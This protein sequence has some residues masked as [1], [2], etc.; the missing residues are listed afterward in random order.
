MK[1]DWKK[2]AALVL[3][4]V[5][6]I[7]LLAGCAS[8]GVSPD[9]QQPSQPVT[10]T[11]A[12]PDSGSETPAVRPDCD[13]LTGGP[14]NPD[15]PADTR[16]V[17]VMLDNASAGLPHRGTSGAS[18]VYEMLTEGG[19]PRLM[20]VYPSAAALGTVGPVRSTR[21]QFVQLAVPENM[22]MLHIGTSIYA[23]DML[24]TM[25]YSTVDGIYLGT[26]AFAFDE[27]RALTMDNSHCFYTGPELAAAAMAEEGI[28]ASGAVQP[29]F[30]FADYEAEPLTLEKPAAA[31]DFA[32]S[33]IAPVNL[34]YNA[35]D[36]KYYKSEY[37]DPQMDERSGL[38]VSY[39][40]VF[41]LGTAVGLKSDGLCTDYDMS[42]G[43]GH[44]F[45]RGT[46]Q[47]ITWRK[48][49]VDSRLE[50]FDTAGNPL[51][52][53]VGTSYVAMVDNRALQ[54]SLAI[55]GQLVADTAE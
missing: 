13:I 9:A 12:D 4:T 18:V 31:V 10:D 55:D 42:Q 40:N 47:L 54:R 46:C 45:T 30:N 2:A 17:A 52:V 50:L 35:N 14:L 16:P 29:L 36:F 39:T 23:T 1:Q 28:P 19:I 38:Q 51:T 22:V 21:D 5:L 26:L 41:V 43:V 7:S 6:C 3:C 53:N 15:L 37:G 49:A 34:T 8:R 11:P 24:R 25:S 33:S 27:T 44:Y 32:F 20:A 48:G